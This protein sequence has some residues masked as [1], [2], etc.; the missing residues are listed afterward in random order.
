MDHVEFWLVWSPEGRLPPHYR[1]GSAKSA[2]N[3]AERLA[4]E[5]PNQSF[6]VLHAT[7]LRRTAEAPVEAFVLAKRPEPDDDEIPF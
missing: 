7:E 2:A 1:H 3:E 4:G 6:Y 5:N